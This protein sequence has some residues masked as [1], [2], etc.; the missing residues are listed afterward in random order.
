[1]RLIVGLGNPGSKYTHTRHNVGWLFLDYLV[2]QHGL[3]PFQENSKFESEVAD[4]E[5]NGTKLTLLKPLTY[6]NES[7]RAVY[8]WTQYYH[9]AASEIVVVHDDLDIKMGEFKIQLGVGPKVHNGLV[10][11]EKT[12]NTENFFRIRIGVDSRTQE[13][14]A[15]I[16]G[17]DYVLKAMTPGE[18][19][20]L[21]NV[22]TSIT[23]PIDGYNNLDKK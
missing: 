22:F 23:L 2:T 21:A 7:G 15:H 5:I 10:S 3:T 17:S 16:T 9:V 6:M 19:S 20:V 13:E 14:R 18:E 11:I 1:M 12:L 8:K 4:V